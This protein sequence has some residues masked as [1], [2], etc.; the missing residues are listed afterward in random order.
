[1]NKSYVHCDFSKRFIDY[2]INAYE[3]KLLLILRIHISGP[4]TVQNQN[5]CISTV[6][7]MC[8]LFRFR[9]EPPAILFSGNRVHLPHFGNIT[10]MIENS[11][12][13]FRS[14][15][16]PLCYLYCNLNT[17][18]HNPLFTIDIDSWVYL[19]Q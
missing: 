16:P 1:M 3:F 12:C 6:M 2:L 10:A 17:Q 13:L 15:P 14:T 5:T 4:A 19:T 8:Q 7:Q 11:R 18:N 9:L